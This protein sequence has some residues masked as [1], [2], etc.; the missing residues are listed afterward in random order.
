[1]RSLGTPGALLMVG[2]LVLVFFALRG[3]DEKYGTFGGRF[4]RK[5]ANQ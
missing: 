2:G 4:A 5:A 3:W 1:M